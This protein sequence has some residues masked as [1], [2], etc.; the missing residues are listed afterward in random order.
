M[1]HLGKA[2]ASKA[3]VASEKADP[4]GCSMAS[5]LLVLSKLLFLGKWGSE[6]SESLFLVKIASGTPSLGY[7]LNTVLLP[8]LEKA[9]I[10]FFNSIFSTYKYHI[11]I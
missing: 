6:S 11:F 2:Q 5:H 3:H 8:G 10:F 7:F 1:P 9:R 4:I